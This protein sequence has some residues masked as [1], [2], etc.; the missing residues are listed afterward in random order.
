MIRI[1]AKSSRTIAAPHLF[2]RILK[3]IIYN[4]CKN[5]TETNKYASFTLC[6]CK[7]LV[8]KP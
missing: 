4:S 7:N 2:C 1:K 5:Y 6:K 3:Q 8:E